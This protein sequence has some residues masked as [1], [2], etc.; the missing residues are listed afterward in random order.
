MMLFVDSLGLTT[1]SH[2]ETTK[3]RRAKTLRFY[4]VNRADILALC[5]FSTVHLSHVKALRFW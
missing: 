2:D 3:K 5:H 4:I 1:F